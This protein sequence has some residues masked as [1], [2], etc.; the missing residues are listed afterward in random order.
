MTSRT[1]P[2]QAYLC[3]CFEYN[4]ETGILKRRWRPRHHFASDAAWKSYNTRFAGDVC[5]SRAGKSGHLRANLDMQHWPVHRLIWRME[6][7]EDPPTVDHWDH[8]TDNNVLTNLRGAS[9][10]E[11]TRNM[12]G[13]ADRKYPSA[14]KGAYRH[15]GQFM[16]FIGEN[17]KQLYL[18]RFET[19][20][21]A[22]EAYCAAARRIHGEFW[23]PGNRTNIP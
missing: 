1:L 18:G 6:T 2:P 4:P 9:K 8:V 13:H 22:H 20:I 12:L 11:N 23:H 7:G 16:S 14:L 17:G 10:A 15:R 21:E 19:E 5:D 3:E